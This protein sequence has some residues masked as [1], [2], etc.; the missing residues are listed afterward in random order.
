[1]TKKTLTSAVLVTL[2]ILMT[3]SVPVYAKPR[4]Y[5]GNLLTITDAVVS[6]S[7]EEVAI[8]REGKMIWQ[9]AFDLTT[10]YYSIYGGC[11]EWPN[12]QGSE[13]TWITY[14]FQVLE[15]SENGWYI[16]KRTFD[17][18]VKVVSAR[19]FITA[20]NAYMAH[21]NGMLVGRDGNLFQP[22]PESDPWNWQTI[23]EC[24]LSRTLKEGSNQLVVYVRNYGLID[25]T[26]M[27]NPTGLIFSIEITYVE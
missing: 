7:G 1:L 25:G 17:I 4:K 19:M 23:E 18:D 12:I 14:D 20:D 5:A 8:F 2:I 9:P 24:D 26:W 11:P 22:T 3:V 13:A 6:G 21:V 16:Y 15:P 27:G 10:S